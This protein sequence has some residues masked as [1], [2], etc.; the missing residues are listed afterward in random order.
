[1]ENFLLESAQPNAK[2]KLIDF[3][4]RLDGLRA[5]SGLGLGLG[6]RL[7][8]VSSKVSVSVKGSG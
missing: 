2:V 4:L 3:G 6:F 5:K 8:Q 7:D 1:M